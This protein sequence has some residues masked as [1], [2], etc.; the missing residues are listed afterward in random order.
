[1]LVYELFVHVKCVLFDEKVDIGKLFLIN[2]EKMYWLASCVYYTYACSVANAQKVIA[3]KSTIQYLLRKLCL[4]D[5][6]HLV[7]VLYWNYTI[8]R[9]D[10]A[11]SDN[12]NMMSSVGMFKT[13]LSQLQKGDLCFLLRRGIFDGNGLFI[14]KGGI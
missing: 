9:E 14:V 7:A 2:W 10:F 6:N 8:K 13:S 12:Q 3:H 5:L 4:G 1:M 11:D